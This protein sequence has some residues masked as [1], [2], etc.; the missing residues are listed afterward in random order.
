[1]YQRGGDGG[2][3]LQV[4][5]ALEPPALVP[6]EPHEVDAPHAKGTPRAL[7]TF[8]MRGLAS[9]LL[10]VSSAASP[11]KA[12]KTGIGVTSLRICLDHSR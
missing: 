5:P 11:E 6:N 4:W 7:H 2:A 10:C 9:L 8:G 1:M 12:N 3:A